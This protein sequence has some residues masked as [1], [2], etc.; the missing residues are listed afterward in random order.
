MRRR[1]CGALNTE[2]YGVIA[3]S[4]G[5]TL[6]GLMAMGLMNWE[7]PTV[8][9]LKTVPLFMLRSETSRKKDAFLLMGPLMV[10]EKSFSNSGAF[11]AAYGLRE[12]K[13]SSPKLKLTFP[14]NLSVPGLVK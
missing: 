12:F 13:A 9:A 4:L 6:P 1:F 11:S 8:T 14:W 2:L 5:D 3:R 7:P 10:P